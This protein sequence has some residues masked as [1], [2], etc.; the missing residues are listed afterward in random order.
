MSGGLLL[1]DKEGKWFCTCISSSF[2]R[3]SVKDAK[4]CAFE[5]VTIIIT[6][7]I[8][9]AGITEMEMSL[10]FPACKIKM[11]VIF[12]FLRVV[13]RFESK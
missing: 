8:I 7:G 11:I 13:W 9:K 1:N 6:A 3:P 12:Y 10:S 4:D 2:S 5:D